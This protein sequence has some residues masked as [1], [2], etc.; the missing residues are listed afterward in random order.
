MLVPNREHGLL[1]GPSLD[2]GKKGR[3]LLM[4]RQDVP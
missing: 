3:D 2:L 4:C 1:E